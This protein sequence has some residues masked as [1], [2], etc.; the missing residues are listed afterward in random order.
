MRSEMVF[1]F[2]SSKR[3]PTLMSK[4]LE[5]AEARIRD[6]EDEVLAN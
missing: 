4:R 2:D 1:S 6:S 5:T 3:A